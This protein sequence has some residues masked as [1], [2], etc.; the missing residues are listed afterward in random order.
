MQNLN[1]GKAVKSTQKTKEEIKKEWEE[2]ILE[3]DKEENKELEEKVRKKGKM[4][5][6]GCSD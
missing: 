6:P 3:W 2:S 1:V 5:G 4:W